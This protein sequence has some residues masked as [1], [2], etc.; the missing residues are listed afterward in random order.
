MAL[1]GF[2]LLVVG[3]GLILRSRTM[4]RTDPSNGH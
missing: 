2:S 1:I 4:A 3:T